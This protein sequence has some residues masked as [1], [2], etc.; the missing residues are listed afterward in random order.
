MIVKS[1]GGYNYDSTDMACIRHRIF[2]EKSSRIIYIT[3]LGQ[4]DHF[5]MI[6]KA[7][8]MA[9]WLDKTKCRVEHM[10]FG[11]ILGEDGTK[12]KSRSGETIKLIKLLDEA[13][14]RA[15][16]QIKKR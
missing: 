7:A 6:F 4:Q 5:F 1:D 15:L 3:D 16:E 11:V 12:F 8:E 14:S 9:G 2:D 10:G 13:K